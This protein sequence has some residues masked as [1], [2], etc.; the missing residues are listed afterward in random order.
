VWQQNNQKKKERK[1]FQ[2]QTSYL[3][4]QVPFAPRKK[5]TEQQEGSVL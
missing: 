4:D 5:I 2:K 1:K 3:A